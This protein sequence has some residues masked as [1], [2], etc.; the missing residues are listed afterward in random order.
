MF[1]SVMSQLNTSSAS[2]FFYLTAEIRWFRRGEVPPEIGE[3]FNKSKYKQRSGTRTDT[4]LVYP[5]AETVGVKFRENRFEIKTFVRTLD[6]LNIGDH[7]RG[8]MEMW[9]K[10]SMAGDSVAGLFK[11]I[12]EDSATWIDVRKTRTMR[13]F[14]TDEEEIV[15]TDAT[16]QS[17]FPGDGCY[18]EITEIEVVG[19]P[20]W[21]I[22]LEAFSRE[23]ELEDSLLRTAS[24]FF[25]SAGDNLILPEADSYSYPVFLRKFHTGSFQS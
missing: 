16:G 22:G 20:F 3:W 6:Q 24:Y 17:G 23:K 12:N 2:S 10:W 11:D 8:T 1:L 21:T 9:E 25:E 19:E 14:S 7:I 18:A 4:Y 15:E 13:V 5:T